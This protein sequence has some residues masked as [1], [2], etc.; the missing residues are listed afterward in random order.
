MSRYFFGGIDGRHGVISAA[1]V[2]QGSVK[3]LKSR[4]SVCY[5]AQ[6]G[7]IHM[8]PATPVCP[9]KGFMGFKLSLSH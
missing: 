1:F 8:S 2:F 3:C 9:I 4:L 5:V 6:R 7:K